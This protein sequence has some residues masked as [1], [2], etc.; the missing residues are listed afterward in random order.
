MS[1]IVTR[2]RFIN[3]IIASDR[4]WSSLP[5]KVCKQYCYSRPKN[6]RVR[7]TTEASLAGFKIK[8]SWRIMI[9]LLSSV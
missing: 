5:E 3:A 6:I 1:K 9:P 4:V 8:S 7:K 2:I